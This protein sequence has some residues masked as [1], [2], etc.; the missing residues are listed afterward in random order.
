MKIGEVVFTPEEVKKNGWIVI[1]CQVVDK[2][3]YLK[4]H[5][6]D[7]GKNAAEI[8][9]DINVFP[10][11]LLPYRKGKVLC[12]KGGKCCDK[13]QKCGDKD[14]KCCDKEGKV[15]CAGTCPIFNKWTI[16]FTILLLAGAA[17]FTYL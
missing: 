16:G 7:K 6:G 8:F 3:A 13:K 2:N 9:K 12:E 5:E 17:T 15:C 14:G 4:D 10:P 11:F 1:E